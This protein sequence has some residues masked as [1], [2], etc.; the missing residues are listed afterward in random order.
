ML[1]VVLL[2]VALASFGWFLR[3]DR[4]EY[5][6]M[7]ALTDTRERQR[8]YWVWTVKA[9]LLF[10]ALSVVELVLLGRADAPLRFP[11]EFAG[12][13]AGLPQLDDFSLLPIAGA[14]VIGGIVGSVVVGF[15][16][17]RRKTAVKVGDFDAL[18]PRNG[19]E[20]AFAALLSVNAGLSEEMF[21]RLLIPLL[22]MVLTGSAVAGFAFAAI[23][24][25]AAH[26]Y[27]GWKGVAATFV[28]G[29]VMTGFYLFSRSLLVVIAFHAIIDL[30]A[31]IVRP[32]LGRLI[33]T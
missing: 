22:V 5:A 28:L 11:D 25:A 9:F 16:E 7:K 32:A 26:L 30:N 14:A 6:R 8:R 15:I 29:L 10:G 19:R 20:M 2:L 21:F 18:L 12:V 23:L 13:A 33:R 1:A 31:L 27:Q 24:F 17:R 4:S 3:G